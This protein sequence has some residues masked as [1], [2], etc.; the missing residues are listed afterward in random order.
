MSKPE[1]APTTEFNRFDAAIGHIAAVPKAEVDR[2]MA[3]GK[4]SR[5][6]KRKG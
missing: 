2:R 3:K 4:K 6:K 1:P 5:E